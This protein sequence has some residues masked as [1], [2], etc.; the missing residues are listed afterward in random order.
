MIRENDEHLIEWGRVTDGFGQTVGGKKFKGG[1]DQSKKKQWLLDNG[2][3][4]I[5]TYHHHLE[6]FNTHRFLQPM[7]EGM[8]SLLPKNIL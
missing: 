6:I 7:R 2:K 4:Q 5:R 1:G 8:F 3:L